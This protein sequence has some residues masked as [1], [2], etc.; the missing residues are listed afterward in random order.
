MS[1]DDTEEALFF[2]VLLREASVFVALFVFFFFFR[3][4][5]FPCICAFACEPT[6][7]QRENENTE[8]TRFSASFCSSF[9]A[10]SPKRSA[11]FVYR[12]NAPPLFLLF[13]N[14]LLLLKAV[15]ESPF[16][17]V[18]KEWRVLSSFAK[19]NKRKKKFVIFDCAKQQQQHQHHATEEE[20]DKDDEGT[21]T[22]TSRNEETQNAIEDASSSS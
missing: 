18:W 7:Q 19:E 11:F 16:F 4:F 22:T 3:L 21:N 6:T 5:F 1:S 15:K 12:S 8:E 10:V 9:K 13:L 17:V 2:A 14:P 20:D